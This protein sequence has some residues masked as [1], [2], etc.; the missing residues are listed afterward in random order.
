MPQHILFLLHGMGHYGEMKDGK[1]V[2]D[3][4]GWFKGAKASLEALYDR[5][6]KED[7]AGGDKFN[8]RF[9]IVEV[10]FDDITEHFR[11]AWENQAQDWSKLGFSDGIANSLTDF[12]QS[13]KAD[14][15]LWTHLADVTLYLA[16]TVREHVKVQV[17]AKIFKTLAAEKG[18]QNLD[19][20]SVLAHSLGSAVAHD[21]LTD[22]RRMLEGDPALAGMV[23]PPKVIC[24]AANVARVLTDNRDLLYDNILAPTGGT[25]PSGY[26]SC[27]HQLDPFTLVAPFAPDRGDWIK[28]GIRFR[29]LTGLK[30]YYLVEDV[31][32]WAKSPADFAK[33][34]AVVPHGFE[35]YMRQPPVVA[36]LWP[37]LIGD[38]PS[39]DL[40]AAVRDAYENDLRKQIEKTVSDKLDKV[41]GKITKD[42]A[43]RVDTAL[44]QLL[45]VLGG[46]A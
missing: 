21:T 12:F 30:D 20:W 18:A 32:K 23:W 44:G 22:V 31:V 2:P 11:S 27:N 26:I 43:K 7:F 29:D 38:P 24:M 9:K 1:F 35:H 37:S 17:A 6:I 28:P 8:D 5:F 14:A 40:E 36:T 3:Q 46:L 10:Q 13:N 19:G 25:N 33:F 4:E 45:G 41:I 16:P 39:A 42:T 15:F 34:A